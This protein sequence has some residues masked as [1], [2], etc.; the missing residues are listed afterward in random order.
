MDFFVVMR[1]LLVLLGTTI[2][3][4]CG[5]GGDSRSSDSQ[6]SNPTSPTASSGYTTSQPLADN[7][8]ASAYKVLLMGNS[9]AAGLLLVLDQLLK[10]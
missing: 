3:A 6:T 9:H 2:V 4:S 8:G 10:Q 7:S 1:L 5:G